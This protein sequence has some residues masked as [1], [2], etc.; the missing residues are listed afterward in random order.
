MDELIYW[1]TKLQE[2][3]REL[4]AATRRSVVDA[5]A[6]RLMLAKR[7]L[8]RL[9]LLGG[10]LRVPPNPKPRVRVMASGEVWPA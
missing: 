3:E 9:G 2:A 8:K 4:E 1:T 7:E 10:S 6:R 5:A